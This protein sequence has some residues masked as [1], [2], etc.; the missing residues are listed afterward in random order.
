M[1]AVNPSV[2]S[3]DNFAL[4]ARPISGDQP[5]NDPDADGIAPEQYYAMNQTTIGSLGDSSSL[6]V[7]PG[8]VNPSANQNNLL[9]A[10]ANPN[11]QPA[12]PNNGVTVTPPNG[13]PPIN[14]FTPYNPNAQRQ[15]S[16]DLAVG[17]GAN[18]QYQIQVN[19][20][21][22]SPADQNRI[23]KELREV[24]QEKYLDVIRDKA[25]FNANDAI[26]G[27]VALGA[28][29]RAGGP[30][31][32]A[33]LGGASAVSSLEERKYD[34]LAAYRDGVNEVLKRNGISPV[35]IDQI[36]NVY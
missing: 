25:I 27:A 13:L 18:N 2:T 6:N 31:G 23:N 26:Q 20:P 34:I 8:N 22:V 11:F 19:S 32:A 10:Q 5:P 36:R 35:K 29:F 14:R 12:K 28:G 17:I 21:N 9:L 7:A 16:P 15:T 30:Y 33:L 1:S 3:N 24:Y 4:N